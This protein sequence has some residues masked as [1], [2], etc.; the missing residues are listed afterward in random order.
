MM[1]HSILTNHNVH[2]S[3]SEEG[4]TF[5]RSCA[6]I[7][8]TYAHVWH[9]VTNHLIISNDKDFNTENRKRYTHSVTDMSLAMESS[10]QSFNPQG[11]W[12]FNSADPSV[13]HGIYARSQEP[14]MLAG[15]GAY[16]CHNTYS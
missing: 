10:Y 16:M 3:D 8:N 6:I 11:Q 2:M 12:K 13:D 5:P 4:R 1:F 14:L 7:I 15:S 9:H